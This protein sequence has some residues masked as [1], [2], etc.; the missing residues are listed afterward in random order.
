MDGVAQGEVNERV[1][2]VGE[3]ARGK[4][5][6][7]DET[8]VNSIEVRASRVKDTSNLKAVIGGKSSKKK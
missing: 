5:N 1:G 8:L 2:R 7:I 3:R 6:R 4:E